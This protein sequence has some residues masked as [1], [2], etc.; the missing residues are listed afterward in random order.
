[1]IKSYH[2]KK[3][4]SISHETGTLPRQL[5]LVLS[6]KMWFTKLTDKIILLLFFPHKCN[7]NVFWQMLMRLPRKRSKTSWSSTTG[8]CWSPIHVAASPR[9]S[10]DLEPVLAT[11]SPTVNPHVHFDNKW[12]NEICRVPLCVVAAEGSREIKTKWVF[13]LKCPVKLQVP[14]FK[15]MEH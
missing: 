7:V 3:Y 11:R 12:R 14:V 1:M 15:N 5:H 9:S 2:L 13:K 8:P 6:L 10:V 4:T